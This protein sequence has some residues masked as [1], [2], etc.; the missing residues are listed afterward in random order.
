MLE[1]KLKEIYDYKAPAKK[2]EVKN[3]GKFLVCEI[4]PYT[5]EELEVGDKVVIRESRPYSKKIRWIVLK[6]V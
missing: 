6:K 2:T 3:N 1:E 5:E 4:L